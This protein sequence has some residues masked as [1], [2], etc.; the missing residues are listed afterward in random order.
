[1]QIQ[2]SRL[3]TDGSSFKLLGRQDRAALEAFF[4]SLD[5]DQ[6]RNYFGGS[7]SNLAI[8]EFCRTI[9]WTCTRI[10]ASCTLDR[11]DGMAVLA[12]SPSNSETV[13]LSM[14]YSGCRA[15]PRVVSNLFDLAIAIAPPRCE[16]SILRDFAMPE[17][18]QLIRERGVGT[19]MANEIRVP[20]HLM[21]ELTAT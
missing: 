12:Y 17:L 4:L 5:F 19:F 7:L 9:D 11:L 16:L 20:V 10:I 6:R 2:S 8:A 15:C 18:I 3:G 13:E 14:A 1:M 21:H